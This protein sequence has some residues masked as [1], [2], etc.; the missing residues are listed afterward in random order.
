[1]NKEV[2]FW[3]SSIVP[4]IPLFALAIIFDKY[5]IPYEPLWIVLGVIF[6]FIIGLKNL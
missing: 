6:A 1:M 5:S 4:W 2:K 3:I